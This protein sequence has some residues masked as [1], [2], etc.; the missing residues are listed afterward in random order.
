VE[1]PT[2]GTGSFGTDDPEG[3]LPPECWVASIS[4]KNI[5]KDLP[6]PAATYVSSGKC[7][8][9]YSYN[10]R[11][12]ESTFDKTKVVSTIDWTAEGTYQPLQKNTW[13]DIAIRQVYLDRPGFVSQGT[14][15]GWVTC[16]KDPWREPDGLACGSPGFKTAGAIEPAVARFYGKALRVPLTS[17]LSAPQRAS[18]KGQYQAAVQKAQQINVVASSSVEKQSSNAFAFQPAVPSVTSPAAN[19]VFFEKVPI[20]IKL[21]SPR[22]LNATGYLVNLETKDA[23]GAW[24]TH[25]TIP[26]GV[27][28]AQSATG[29]TG[30]GAGAPPAF[31]ALPGKWRLNA[32]ISS[33]KAS[34]PSAWVEFSVVS[35]TRTR[36]K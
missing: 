14:L 21:T 2:A 5:G 31:L 17:N 15:S 32:Q 29:Y 19:Q 16:A 25:A 36:R 28:Q 30:F 20:P 8:I 1:H 27:A 6:T 13:E 4:L 26:V 23:N 35:S 3:M 33:P 24:R 22:A 7:N 9:R 34:G 12:V 18:L 11:G 10:T